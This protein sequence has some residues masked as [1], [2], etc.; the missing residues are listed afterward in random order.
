[1]ADYLSPIVVSSAIYPVAANSTF[2][3][4]PT[5]LLNPNRT[6]ML[7]DQ[8]R[9][10]VGNETP[11]TA[12]PVLFQSYVSIQMGSIYLTNGMVPLASL[13]PSY[14]NG[15]GDHT[16]DTPQQ[17]VWHLPKPL[18]V[19]PNVVMYVNSKR[20]APPGATTNY[21]LR[22]AVAGRSLPANYPIPESIYVP[23]ATASSVDLAQ[24]TTLAG[25]QTYVTPDNALGNPNTNPLMVTRMLGF[26]ASYDPA[27]TTSV[28]NSDTQAGPNGL[29]VR[30]T[31]S[32]GKLLVREAT[33]FFHLFP[34][35][36]RYVDL[37]ATLRGSEQVRGGE[38]V[39]ARLDFTTTTQA[40]VALEN[41][42]ITTLGLIGYRSVPTPPGAAQ[43][44]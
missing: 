12:S 43:N 10:S 14:D 26:H 24:V 44:P 33:P 39:R 35:S 7:V 1:M 8:F 4:N 25:M 9:F 11:F 23:W 34:A 13:C 6:A 22:V 38:F 27:S 40:V 29:T 3:V 15:W 32:N 2:Q 5:E 42:P 17:Y 30:M 16:V 36:R 31:I 20:V 19:P 21:S 37:R 18:Y 28:S 41:F